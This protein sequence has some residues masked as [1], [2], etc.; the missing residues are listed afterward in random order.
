MLYEC[1]LKIRNKA[2][3]AYPIQMQVGWVTRNTIITKT[4]KG[5]QNLFVIYAGIS[6]K[7][8]SNLCVYNRGNSVL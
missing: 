1:N 3:N 4:P 5:T 7:G 2:K 6:Y 8:T